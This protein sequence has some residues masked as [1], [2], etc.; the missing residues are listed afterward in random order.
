MQTQKK[1]SRFMSHLYTPPKP[2]QS[3]SPRPRIQIPSEDEVSEVEPPEFEEET[4][5][6]ELLGEW[7]AEPGLGA[8]KYDDLTAIGTLVDCSLLTDRLDP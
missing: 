4:Y 3:R 7:A 2:T 5:A 6:K 8:R 1:L